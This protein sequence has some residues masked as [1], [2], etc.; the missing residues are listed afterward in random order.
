MKK[1]IFILTIVILLGGLTEGFAQKNRTLS[2]G[3]SIKAQLGFPTANYGTIEDVDDEF[4]FGPSYGLQIGNQWYFSPKENYGFGLMVNWFDVT[5]TRK[6]TDIAGAEFDRASTDYSLLEF[7]PVGTYALNEEM[8]VDGYYN[9]RPTIMATA[10]QL[11]G[12]DAEGYGGFGITHAFGAGFRYNV[13]YFGLEYVLGSV[14]V[15]QDS[16]DPEV[17]K[18][19]KI[20]VNCLRILLGIKF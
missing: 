10:Y 5:F 7:G 17:F 18:D 6:K 19:E 14:K 20:N 13:L 3:F 4:K 2:K 16:T 1:S 8:A 9:L 15:S 12:E 11:E